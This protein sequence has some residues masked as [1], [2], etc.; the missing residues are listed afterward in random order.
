M[1]L[2]ELLKQEYFLNSGKS[3]EK[4]HVFEIQLIYLALLS[5]DFINNKILFYIPSKIIARENSY[6]QKCY[7]Y[8]ILLVLPDLYASFIFYIACRSYM[9]KWRLWIIRH[10]PVRVTTR[11]YVYA[12]AYVCLS[13]RAVY[14]RSLK[15]RPAVVAR[16]AV[17]NE[18]RARLTSDRLPTH[19][20]MHHGRVTSVL[21]KWKISPAAFD[22]FP[23]TS[24]L[25]C[26]RPFKYPLTIRALRFDSSRPE[27][28]T[29][30]KSRSISSVINSNNQSVNDRAANAPRY[31]SRVCNLSRINFSFN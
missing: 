17:F 15:V 3:G 8:S 29:S 30:V 28:L 24:A 25:V 20:R 2:F 18:T 31:V 10:T 22:A 27:R 23:S 14:V 4:I 21:F 13:A 11:W 7:F 19:E 26:S 16:P 1:P 5:S 9:N 12:P 6:T